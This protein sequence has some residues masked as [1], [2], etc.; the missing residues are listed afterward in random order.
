MR[1]DAVVLKPGSK[2]ETIC[3]ENV[4]TNLLQEQYEALIAMLSHPSCEDHILWGLVYML[5]D[6]MDRRFLEV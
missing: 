3:F 4:D 6:E 1:G 5:G 2:N